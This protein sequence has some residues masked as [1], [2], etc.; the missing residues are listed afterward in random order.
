MI[1]VEGKVHTVS[2]NPYALRRQK[3]FE[4]LPNHS[5]MVLPANVK[6]KR[7]GDAEYLFR[8]ESYFYYVSGFTEDNALIVL[9]KTDKQ[10][11][12]II[13]CQ[14]SDPLEAR[15]QGPRLGLT[16]AKQR[17]GADEAYLYS[18]VVPILKE[19]LTPTVSVLYY[20]FSQTLKI[21][22]LLKAKFTSMAT[23]RDAGLIL[24]ELRLI[25]D[26]HE[27][28]LMRKAAQISAKAHI[29]AM[30][31]CQSDLFEYELEAECLYEF[32]RKGARNPAY[33]S[34]VGAGANACILHYTDN[35]SLL[36][37][38]ALVL[39]D[40]GAEYQYYA[41]DITR[42][43]PV[44]GRFTEA[45]KIIYNLVLKAQLAAIELARPNQP[46]K[47]MQAAIVK[48]FEEGLLELGIIQKSSDYVKYYMHNSG[49]WLGLDV[50]D[51]GAYQI[52]GASRLLKP[53]MVLTVEPG[54]YF[55]A[56]C[57]EIDEK[58]R[59]IGIRIEDDILV[60]EQAPEILSHEVPKTVEAIEK[61]MSTR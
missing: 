12:F 30:K 50:H 23:H 60:T 2:T 17:L 46:F 48:I 31:A 13:F 54:L 7:N 14:D 25:K 43:F 61:L 27:I 41:A 26:E 56:D 39:I 36:K 45:Q 11:R 57:L 58:W 47:A 28:D 8:Q 32:T 55:P 21:D 10:A 20:P 6:I 38:G 3:I 53:G 42:V 5:A 52:E 4:A 37:N 19:L 33:P 34:I 22:N 59:G 1:K 16:G 15:W 9:L 49:H 40:A 35:Q 29:K 18:E 24:N 44:N 51:V